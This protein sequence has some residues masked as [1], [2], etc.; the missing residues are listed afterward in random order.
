MPIINV[1]VLALVVLTVGGGCKPRD[2]LAAES[3]ATSLRSDGSGPSL[4]CSTRACGRHLGA[5]RPRSVHAGYWKREVCRPTINQSCSA[6][7]VGPSSFEAGPER[8]EPADHAIY[9]GERG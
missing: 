4:S 7:I 5:S 6:P 8:G 1:A 3:A 9:L 2:A